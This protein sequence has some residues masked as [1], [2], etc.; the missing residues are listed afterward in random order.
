MSYR[1]DNQEALE[2]IELIQG[3]IESYSKKEKSLTDD[4]WIKNELRNNILEIDEKEIE[5]FSKEVLETIELNNRNIES[6]NRAIENGV[7][8]E[9]WF[10][11]KVQEASA[12]MSVNQVGQYLQNIDNAIN[13]AN[14]LMSQVI[15]N[16]D[17]TI[18]RNINLDGFIFEQHHANSFNLDVALK[19]GDYK[20]EAL[21]PNPGEIYKRNSVDLVIKDNQG[22]IV[23]K[24]QAKFS[25]DYK[26]AT[27][28]FKK[29]NYKFQGKLVA[30]G[31]VENVAKSTD[32]IS[33][34]NYKS[35]PLS[36]Q[37]GK[38]LQKLAQSGKQIEVDW[39]YYK[40]KDL[41]S[42]MTKNVALAG[43]RSAAIAV[44]YDLV[45][46]SMT[47]KNIEVNEVVELALKT[48]ADSGVKTS[49]TVALKIASEKGLLKAIPP[50]TPPAVIANIATV[51]IENVKVLNKV[52]NGELSVTQGLQQMERV[53]V[54][55]VAGLASAELGTVTGSVAGA[56]AL[57]WIPIVGSPVG[58]VIGGIVGGTVA[59][60]AGSTIGGK[61]CETA[62]KV[63]KTVV[64]SLKT[65]ARAVGTAV[66]KAKNFVKS[67]F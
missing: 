9:A 6:I 5:V 32:T 10:Q 17:G 65:G 64:A 7:S 39:N 36:K 1:G 53:T 15:L 48:G 4:A 27:I 54:A 29:G 25:S 55:T 33:I 63:R 60:M 26:N 49:V 47:N 59:Y 13:N 2:L 12:G 16:N 51:S 66:N 38:E 61:I 67:L 44:G 34:K 28:A 20:A 58:A 8:K 50:G 30:K 41:T 31:Q 23:K 62:Q 11:Q 14:D 46:K 21:K 42:H 19:G 35:T 3:T 24:Y 40:L 22:R 45:Y 56:L 57:S 52:A 18:N 43:V 37:E